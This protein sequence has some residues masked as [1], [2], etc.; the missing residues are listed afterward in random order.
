MPVN[1]ASGMT[2]ISILAENSVSLEDIDDYL[3]ELSEVGIG[4]SQFSNKKF[5]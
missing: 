2:N 3:A 5:P 4:K 1:V